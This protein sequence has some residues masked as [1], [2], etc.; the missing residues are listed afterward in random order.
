MYPQAMEIEEVGQ[1]FIDITTPEYTPEQHKYLNEFLK[2][3]AIDLNKDAARKVFKDKIQVVD[4][5]ITL[6][7][8]ANH[9]HDEKAILDEFKDEIEY[10]IITLNGSDD[11]LMI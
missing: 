2:G 8:F 6:N 3:H 11:G 10:L 1:A 4:A 9:Y 7:E 5:L